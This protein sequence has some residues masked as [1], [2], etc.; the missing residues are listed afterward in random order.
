M[1]Q[2]QNAQDPLEFV[3]GMWNSMGFSLPGMV[4]PTLDVEELDKRITDMKAV[5]GWLK[6]NLNMLQMS[7]QG[8]E[9]QRAAIAAVKA[10]GSRANTDEAASEASPNPFA[11]AAAMWPWNLMNPEQNQADTAKAGT[12]SKTAARSTRRK[13]ADDK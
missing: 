11:A 7:I 1:S 10:M 8:L 6:M 12:E 3:R 5:E 2:D 13:P 4:T 9:L